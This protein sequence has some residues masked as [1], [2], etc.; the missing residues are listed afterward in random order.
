MQVSHHPPI[1]A[2]Y[3][4][5]RENSIV[6][7]GSVHTKYPLQPLQ[8]PPNLSWLQVHVLGMYVLCYSG[9]DSVVR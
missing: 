9:S 5:S 4:E 7:E 2:V 3:A 8:P 6:F 1:T